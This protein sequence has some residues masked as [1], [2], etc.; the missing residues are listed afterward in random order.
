MRERDD[1]KA[2]RVATIRMPTSLHRALQVAGYQERTSMN[3]LALVGLFEI[4]EKCAE[5]GS[6]LAEW[7]CKT[8]EELYGPECSVE[9]SHSL[10][11]AMS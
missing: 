2:H 5:P 7:V 8:R 11:E 9:P 3:K 4:V 1:Y 10:K 6:Q